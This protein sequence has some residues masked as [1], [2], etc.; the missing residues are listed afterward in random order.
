MT[1][2]PI[3]THEDYLKAKEQLESLSSKTQKCSS[4]KEIETLRI[5]IENYEQQH[6]PE[7]EPNTL[8]YMD[9]FY[10][11]CERMLQ[12]MGIGDQQ[13]DLPA[14]R[15]DKHL[16]LELMRDIARA[17]NQSDG[18]GW[19]AALEGIHFILDHSDHKD[20]PIYRIQSETELR[21]CFMK[22]LTL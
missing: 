2:Q 17:L 19:E 5:M 11:F 4:L 10:H 6:A 18:E 12:Q 1:L 13:A 22:W 21:E 14:I 16:Q 7:S 9:A 20:A 8:L 3:Q 15:A